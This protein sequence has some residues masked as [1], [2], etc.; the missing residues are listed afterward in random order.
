[1]PKL[2][3]EGILLRPIVSSIQSPTENLPKFFKNIL[4]NVINKKVYYFKN[5]SIL[6]SLYVVS[7]YTGKRKIRDKLTT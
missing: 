1:M 6:A 4:K 5:N 3:K 7:L 2:H